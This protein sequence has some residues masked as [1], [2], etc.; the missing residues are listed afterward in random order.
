MGVA[1]SFVYLLLLSCFGHH[2]IGSVIATRLLQQTPAETTAAPGLYE[3]RLVGGRYPGE[4]RVEMFDGQDWGT[5]CGDTFWYSEAEV[6]CRQLGYATGTMVKSWG[7]G[8]G[9]IL[10]GGVD[11]K[12]DYETLMPALNLCYLGYRG[13]DCRHAEDVGVR[14]QGR[15]LSPAEGST[16]AP[17]YQPTWPEAPPPPPVPPSPPLVPGVIPP[18]KYD[19]RLVGGDW[20]GEGRLEVFDGRQWGTICEDIHDEYTGFGDLE[21]S[22]VCRELGYENGTAV[23][24][25]TDY[26]NSNS[27]MPVWG[28][29]LGP[30][31]MYRVDCNV[32]P[33]PQ[34]LHQC[35][36]INWEQDDF[37]M[38][39]TCNHMQDVGVRCY[40]KNAPSSLY[41]PSPPY[42]SVPAT[43]VNLAL[44]QPAFASSADNTRNFCRVPTC[45]P[46]F[47][48]DGKKADAGLIFRSAGFAGDLNPWLSVDLG[49]VAYVY[50]I[51]LYYRIDCCG[52]AM[53]GVELRVGNTSIIAPEDVGLIRSNPL[54]WVE[55]RPYTTGGVLDVNLPVPAVG[56]WVTLQNLKITDY[57]V[58]R[59]LEVVELE[60]YGLLQGERAQRPPSPSPPPPPPLLPLPP[61]PRPPRRPKKPPSPTA[62]PPLP[63]SGFVP[64]ALA[65]GYDSTCVLSHTA[66]ALKCFGFGRFGQLGSG[67]NRNIGDQPNEMGSALPPVRFGPGLTPTSIAG[68]CFHM[69]AIL[70]PGG[71]VKCWGYNGNG[72]LGLGDTLSRG[73]ERG[74]M[75]ANLAAVDLGTGLTATALVAGCYHTCALLQPGG[76]VKCWGSNSAGQL[77]IGDKVNRGDQPG[78]MGDSLPAVD[79]GPGYAVTALA[80]GLYHTCAILQPRGAIKCWGLNMYGQLGL[81]DTTNRGDWPRG[82]GAEL[83]IVDVG[84]GLSA[85]A[86]AA[87]GQHTCA[88]LQPGSILKCW[89]N[90][91]YGQLGLGNKFDRG[92]GQYSGEMGE[93]LP[94]VN[95]GR[96]SVK[97]VAIT[98]GEFFS[99]ALMEPGGVIKCWGLNSA[100]QLGIGNT[101]NRGDQSD[102]M[103][104][105]LPPVDL[106]PGLN[107]SMMSAGLH[108]VC[109]VLKPTSILKCW[110]EN[111]FGAL[112]L[113]DKRDR[114][115]EKHHMGANLSSV[116]L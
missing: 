88:I 98:L 39:I 8:T 41:Q 31:L 12:F 33:I 37:Y 93:E 5:I 43:W 115:T 76:I 24:T 77:G 116:D 3:I 54:V 53:G 9:P 70:Q 91:L 85:T 71:V 21:A 78:Q 100:G 38:Y 90:N 26:Y 96:S 29:G 36:S 109:A 57:Y 22:V 106:G 27:I 105:K 74:E 19:V 104:S 83:P 81:G 52:E 18:A 68:G 34:T 84:T 15:L 59:R 10:M 79:L 14:C 111:Q 64:G 6:V 89:G 40:G 80:S 55:R 58:P 35:R 13:N 7:G 114:G 97:L 56:R 94:R 1:V 95:L 23:L 87:G 102:E 51:Q 103:G 44:G 72:Q 50:R 2:F 75:G 45:S 47:A 63:P 48:F 32:D 110:G 60:V 61:S 108:H 92:S 113:G 67:N 99:C 11:C 30:V 42:P 69:C 86:I 82:M 16:S 66:G 73:D 49:A 4:G 62:P 20:P 65:S 101:K 25:G 28:P 17:P 107:A 46:F 112:G